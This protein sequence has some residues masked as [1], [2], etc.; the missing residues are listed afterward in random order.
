MVEY[1]NKKYNERE[2][3]ITYKELSQRV[4]EK[5]NENVEKINNS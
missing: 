5:Y 3:N 4:L 2:M 1:F